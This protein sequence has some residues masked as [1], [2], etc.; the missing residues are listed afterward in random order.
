MKR[1]ILIVLALI[2]AAAS[3]PAFAKRLPRLEQTADF[4]TISDVIS[5]EPRSLNIIKITNIPSEIRRLRIRNNGQKN[6]TQKRRVKV[7]NGTARLKF[8]TRSGSSNDLFILVTQE[9]PG[10]KKDN[11]AL[12]LNLPSTDT[13]TTEAAP[14][15]GLLSFTVCRN[16][17]F[18]TCASDDPVTE[19]VNYNNQCELEKAGATVLNQGPCL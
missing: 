14:V 10:V 8:K 11:F 1:S 19:A 6:I 7:K 12:K 13:C 5:L 9:T 17:S 2:F 3:S 18:N 4:T 15:C 16:S